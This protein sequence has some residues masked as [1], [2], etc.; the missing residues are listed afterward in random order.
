MEVEVLFSKFFLTLTKLV[1]H[2]RR[3]VPLST[4]YL[5]LSIHGFEKPVAKRIL[6]IFK[7]SGLISISTRGIKIDFKNFERFLQTKKEELEKL[8]GK[9]NVRKLISYVKIQNNFLL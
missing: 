6:K 3:V 1:K 9:K 7:E 5:V 8:L 2:V 4:A